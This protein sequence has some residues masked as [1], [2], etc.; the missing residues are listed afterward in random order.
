MVGL[1]RDV[2]LGPLQGVK[3]APEADYAGMRLGEIQRIE[4]FLV[5]VV[6]FSYEIRLR[7]VIFKVTFCLGQ[8]CFCAI[9]RP[10]KVKIF[11]CAGP[12]I[13]AKGLTATTANPATSSSTQRGQPQRPAYTTQAPC[14]RLRWRGT[15]PRSR[16]LSFSSHSEPMAGG[17]SLFQSSWKAITRRDIPPESVTEAML[18]I[19]CAR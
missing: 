4:Y 10:R 14:P 11:I 17:K 8:V 9:G 5:D 15:V 13:N 6:V 19:V 12:Q 3:R 7:R 16:I 18:K 2:A 1:G